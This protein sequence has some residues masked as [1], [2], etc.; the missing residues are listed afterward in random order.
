MGLQHGKNHGEPVWVPADDGAARGAER[1]R[2]DEC[3]NLHQQRPRSF[4]SGEHGGAGAAEVAL[5]EEQ[6]GGICDFAQSR[7]GHFEHADFVGRAEAVLDG[8]QNAELMRAF[9]FERHHGVDHVLD[10]AG[11]GDLAILGD[12][13]D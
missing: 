11:A 6:L 5:G 10:D 1:R 12:V 4:Y 2:R 7:A 9:A 13:A 8:A 3:L